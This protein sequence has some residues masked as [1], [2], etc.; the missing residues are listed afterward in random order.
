MNTPQARIHFN[1]DLPFTWR[2]GSEGAQTG[3]HSCEIPE[4]DLVVITTGNKAGTG[5]IE[6][7]CRKLQ[8]FENKEKDISVDF[9]ILIKYIFVFIKKKNS[10]EAFDGV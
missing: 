7:Q 1:F 8:I 3:I 4:L 6:C 9:E 10:Y 2:Y 5:W